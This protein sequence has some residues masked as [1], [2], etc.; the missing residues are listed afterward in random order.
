MITDT[1][2]G[3]PAGW[4]DSWH[5]CARVAPVSA[6]PRDSASDLGHQ[7]GHLLR[8]DDRQVHRHRLPSSAILSVGGRRIIN[9]GMTGVRCA[10]LDKWGRRRCY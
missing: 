8:A 4:P 7:H 1:L 5:R 2:E 9:V 3:K 10:N 6:S